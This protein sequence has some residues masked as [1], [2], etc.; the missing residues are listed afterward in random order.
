MLLNEVI[1]IQTRKTV[2]HGSHEE[3]D[4]F[5][6]NRIGENKA[7][8]GGWGIYLSESEEVARQYTPEGKGVLMQFLLPTGKYL[9]LDEVMDEYSFNDIM[10]NLEYFDERVYKKTES[11]REEIE[12]YGFDDYQLTGLQFYE[13][14]AHDFGSKKKMSLFLKDCGF[15]GNTFLDKTKPN[16]RNYVLFSTD[17]LRRV[18]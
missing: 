15:M 14:I 10:E 9:N 11:F 8:K 5:D 12:S 18:S 4:S 6:L 17:G 1:S 2:F 3:F 16:V 7:D 13:I